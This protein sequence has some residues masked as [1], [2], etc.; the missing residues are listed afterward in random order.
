MSEEVD[1]DRVDQGVTTS[2][3][4]SAGGTADPQS[5]VPGF[6]N[7]EALA[8]ELAAD[9][10]GAD[11]EAG[12]ARA[13]AQPVTSEVDR[14]LF[15]QATARIGALTDALAAR[16]QLISAA[17]HELRNALAPLLLLTEQLNEIALRTPDARLAARVEKLTRH[18]RKL[19]LTVEQVAEISQ[20]RSAKIAIEIE[21]VD[22]AAEVRNLVARRTKQA[23][24]GEAVLVVE[25][26]DPIYGLWDR[27]RLRQIVEHLLSNAMRYGGSQTIEVAVRRREQG[28]E[29]V[30]RDH[31]PGVPVD[32]LSTIFDRLDHPFRRTAGGLG[33]GLFVVRALCRAMGGDVSAENAPDGG[34]RFTVF[35]PRT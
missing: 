26:P 6:V 23:L 24:A 33:V 5:P 10:D 20:L 7:T 8:A 3:L 4:G 32:E 35:L 9:V 12:G 13:M 22:M 16:D 17:G 19:V 31:G 30:V 15:A 34:A 2:S 11:L 18:F 29:L 21:H 27:S 1:G 25:A 28:A 14:L